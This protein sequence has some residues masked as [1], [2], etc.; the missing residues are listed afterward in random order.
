MSGLPE[1]NGYSHLN[2]LDPMDRFEDAALQLALIT[3]DVRTLY[4]RDARLRAI[5]A[6]MG[7]SLRAIGQ[8]LEMI[9]GQLPR[10]EPA[11]TRNE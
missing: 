8:T 2:S 6:A 11:E 1:L 4:L 9:G 10:P 5:I 3:A 7:G